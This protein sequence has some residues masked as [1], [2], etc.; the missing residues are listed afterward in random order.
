MDCSQRHD[1]RFCYTF[2]REVSD[3]IAL[4]IG[5]DWLVVIVIF[6]VLLF[7]LWQIRRLRASL[8]RVDPFDHLW[9]GHIESQ[10]SQIE[11]SLSNIDNEVHEIKS[12]KIDKS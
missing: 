3:I 4:E 8:K 11:R 7:F 12:L 9:Y 2:R 5:R 10:I 1:Y 6:A